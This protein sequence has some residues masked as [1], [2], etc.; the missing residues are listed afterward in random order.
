MQEFIRLGQKYYFTR[1]QDFWFG[2]RISDMALSDE[3]NIEFV[4]NLVFLASIS[5]RQ[6]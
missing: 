6:I 5:L 3:L 1:T 4:L 2:S